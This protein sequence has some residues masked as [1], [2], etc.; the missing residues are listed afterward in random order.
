M[1]IIIIAFIFIYL[2]INF[3]LCWVFVV[4][5]GLSL[6]VALAFLLLQS[7]SSMARQLSHCALD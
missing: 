4:V 5:H 3:W 2:K 1:T 6:V 7:T